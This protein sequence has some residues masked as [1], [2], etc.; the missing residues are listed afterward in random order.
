MVPELR[1]T[2]Y[3]IDSRRIYIGTYVAFFCL[4]IFILLAELLVDLRSTTIQVLM[5]FVVTTPLGI[6]LSYRF[7]HLKVL[8]L[9][10]ILSMYA[11]LEAHFLINPTTFHVIIY[12]FPLIP[13]TAL[14]VQGLRASQVWF[15]ITLLTN[16]LN[17]YF[18]KSTV[19]GTYELSINGLAFFA[20]STI[21]LVGILAAAYLLYI[22]LGNAY[23]GVK[24]SNSELKELKNGIEKKK[25]MLQHYQEDLLSFSKDERIFKGGQRLMFQN[26]CTAAARSLN[27]NRVSLWLFEDNARIIRKFLYDRQ[28]P[29]DDIVTLEKKDY[30]IYLD[31]LETKEIVMA[32]DARMSR[33][34]MELNENYLIPLDIRSTLDCSITVDR[35]VVGM[36]CCENRHAIKHWSAEDGLFL[37]SLTRFI[38]L[39]FK[40]EQ[41][42]TLLTEVRK[43]NF[44]LVDRSL[45]IGLMNERLND[46]NKELSTM[47]E[48]L[49]AAVQKRTSELENQNKQLAEYAFINSHLLRAPLSRIIG[50]SHLIAREV[51]SVRE[52]ELINALTM[53]TN[54]LDSIIRKIGDLLNNRTN[55]T[56][57]DIKFIEAKLNS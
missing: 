23:L 9:G 29:S 3:Q 5:P 10:L 2:D 6:Y 8:R 43:Q 40:N 19:G 17:Y 46:L 20:A 30:P 52:I 56:R 31:E 37:Q 38:S 27:V 24:E 25:E 42:K 18:L 14:I 49:E 53:S 4:I 1:I 51:T 12:W 45:K 41:I 39:R 32:T 26:F 16:G 47:N 50:L 48:T 34:T 15:V 57:D 11:I 55:L 22:L 21:F 54:E 35:K 7:P 36:I 28:N 33:T 13:L 44:Q